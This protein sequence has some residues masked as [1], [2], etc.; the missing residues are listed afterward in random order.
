MGYGVLGVVGQLP[1]RSAGSTSRASARRVEGEVRA[2]MDLDALEVSRE[3]ERDDKR[4][5][6]ELL[7][8]LDG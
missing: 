5:L 7:D 4:R 6:D 1:T 3:D 2:R 8:R